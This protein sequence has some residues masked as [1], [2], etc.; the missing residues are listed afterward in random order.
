M[1]Q[2]RSYSVSKHDDPLDIIIDICAIATKV[3]QVYYI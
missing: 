2:H 3:F 1:T